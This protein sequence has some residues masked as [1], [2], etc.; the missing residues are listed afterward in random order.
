MLKINFKRIPQR[1]WQRWKC[2]IHCYRFKEN[3]NKEAPLK[4]IKLYHQ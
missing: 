2:E 3:P 1:N 4:G